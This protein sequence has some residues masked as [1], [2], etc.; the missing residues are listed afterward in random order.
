M[1]VNRRNVFFRC[2]FLFGCNP[3]RLQMY[4]TVKFVFADHNPPEKA[5]VMKKL[6]GKKPLRQKKPLENF[7][8]SMEKQKVSGRVFS[9]EGFFQRRVFSVEGHFIGGAF[10]EGVFQCD[11]FL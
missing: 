11:S 5:P 8:F 6:L 1:F 9:T 10:L 2:L 3:P 4:G 7:V